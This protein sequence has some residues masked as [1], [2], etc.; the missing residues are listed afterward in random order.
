[1]DHDWKQSLSLWS[2][3]CWV[4]G[5]AQGELSEGQVWRGETGKADGQEPPRGQ[6]MRGASFLCSVYVYF[7]ESF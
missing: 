7:Y 3:L 1:M 2:F 5:R 4:M 6:A